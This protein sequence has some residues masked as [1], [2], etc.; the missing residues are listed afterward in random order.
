MLVGYLL[1]MWTNWI[2]FKNTGNSKCLYRNELDKACFHH[3][4]AYY[5]TNNLANKAIPDKVLKE[6]VDE[7]ARNPKYDGYQRALANI[8]HKFFWYKRRSGMSENEKLAE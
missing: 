5:D 6:K 3:D 2:I 4:A 8:V 1:S 7:I